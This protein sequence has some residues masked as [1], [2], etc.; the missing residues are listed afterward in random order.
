M[1]HCPLK[2]EEAVAGSDGTPGISAAK[3]GR[4][5]VATLAVTLLDV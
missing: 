1:V 2:R 4:R 3:Q 5:L